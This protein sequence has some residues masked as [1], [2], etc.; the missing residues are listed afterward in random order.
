MND[1]PVINTSYVLLHAYKVLALLIVNGLFPEYVAVKSPLVQL[2]P[3]FNHGKI[4]ERFS[5]P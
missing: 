2:P 5:L 4:T 1:N 3:I